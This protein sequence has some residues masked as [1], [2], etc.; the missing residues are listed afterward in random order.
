MRIVIV[1]MLLFP[2]GPVSEATDK[3]DSPAVA[4]AKQLR[5]AAGMPPHYW[6]E[7]GQK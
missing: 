3:K 7:R 1:V 5:N 6:C 2:M 4:P